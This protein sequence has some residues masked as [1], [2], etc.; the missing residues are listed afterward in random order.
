MQAFLLRRI[1]QAIAVLFGVSIITFIL[2]HLLP[3][4]P[5]KA[6]LGLRANKAQIA[7]FDLKFGLLKPLPFQYID[8]VNQLLH[9][10]LGFSY[11]LNQSVDSLL[12]ENVPRTLALVGVSTALA[13]MVAIP[14][15]IYQAVRRNKPEDYV[16]TGFSFI[17]YSM[18]SFF[19]GTILIILLS[20]LL[21]FFPSIGPTATSPLW[22]QIPNLVLPVLTLTLITIALFSRYMRSSVLENLVQDYVRTA[23]S[24]GVSRRVILFRHVLPNAMLPIITLIGLSLPGILS[25]ALIT[26]SIFNYP[27]MGLLFW[28]AAQTEDFPVMLGTTIVVGVAVVI[29]SLVADILYAVFDPRIRYS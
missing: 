7:A 20:Q 6:A 15:G 8:W 10:N 29:G 5:A 12:S 4:G 2:L 1:L 13:I 19:L 14:A 27:G 16:L 9:G 24:K 18:P 22:Q 17:F 11:K 3:G 21:P 23:D 28:N 26:E 25:G